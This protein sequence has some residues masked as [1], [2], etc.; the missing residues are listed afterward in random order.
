MSNL[1]LTHYPLFRRGKV[2]DVYDLGEE[3]LLVA[4]DRLST[5]D[6]VMPTEIPDKGRLLTATSL[7]WFDQIADIVPNHLV[8]QSLGDLNLNDA[9][10]DYLAGRTT[11]G[12]KAERIDIECVVRGY[13]AGSGWK[14]YQAHG[15]LAGLPLPD[16]LQLGSALPHPVFTPAIKNDA[17]HD[18]N[19]S[20][21]RLHQEIDP[22]LA[23]ALERISLALYERASG[24][25]AKAGFVLADTKF[26]FGFIDGTLSL[27][28]EVLTPDSSRYWEASQL[29]PG[30]EP[31]SFDKQ[32]IRDWVETTGW[33]KQA[34]GPTIP[35]EIVAE[36]RDRYQAVRDRLAGA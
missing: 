25:A 22:T 2:R 26:E 10:R 15:T 17:G 24:I 36:A 13:L 28:D 3:L 32:L 7:W 5:F 18:E 29:E 20:V 1:T 14:E 27:I 31:P 12:R 21:A 9:E 30:K 19:I 6:V 4:T 34:P 23:E 33:N 35:A 8:D 11:R 16:G